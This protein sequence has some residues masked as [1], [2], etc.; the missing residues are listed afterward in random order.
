MPYH[1]ENKKKEWREKNK[2]RLKKYRSEWGK[3]NRKKLSKKFKEWC[4]QNP[5]KCKQYDDKYNSSLKGRYNTAK[6]NAK[7]RGKSFTISFEDFCNEINKPCY[8]CN[9]EIGDK[10]ITGSGLDRVDNTKG[11]DLDNIKSCCKVCNTI[12]GNFLT[13]EETMIA[14]KAII[15]FR[16]SFAINK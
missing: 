6:G 10:S 1:D 4:V 9:N 7:R 8:Y 3:Q 11:Y 14:V 16:K 13:T 12:K 2:E 15:D 5:D